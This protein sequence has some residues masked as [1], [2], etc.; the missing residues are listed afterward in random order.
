VLLWLSEGETLG[1]LM[2]E[3][4][5]GIIERLRSELCWYLI[6]AIKEESGGWFR[7]MVVVLEVAPLTIKKGH[8]DRIKRQTF[9]LYLAT[10]E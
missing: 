4:H 5:E 7:L 1:K 8:E 9:R 3:T 2:F 10:L 6:V